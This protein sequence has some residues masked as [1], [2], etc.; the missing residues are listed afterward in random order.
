MPDETEPLKEYQRRLVER[1]RVLAELTWR[2]GAVANARLFVFVV[3]AVVVWFVFGVHRLHPAWIAIPVLAFLSLVVIHDRVLQSM[4]C[5]KSGIEYYERGIAR[6][7]DRWTGTGWDG[8]DLAPKEH[9]YADDLDLFGPGS[10]FQLLCTAQ[11]RAGGKTLADWLCTSATPDEIRAR[12]A[13]VEELRHR[14]DLREELA[15]HGRAIQTHV[16]PEAIAAWASAPPVFRSR[17][18]AVVA[19]VVSLV[20]IVT[21]VSL[22]FGAPVLPF[23]A[24]AATLLALHLATRRRVREVISAADE[25]GRELDLAGRVLARLE[26]EPFESPYLRAAQDGFR[27]GPQ[28]ASAAIAR[29]RRLLTMREASLNMLFAPIAPFL[30]WDFHFARAIDAWRCRCGPAIG[31]WLEGVGRLEALCAL[32]S[33]AYEHPA[34][35]FP[36]VEGNGLVFNGQGLGHPLLPVARCV[37]NNVVLD[38][39]QRLLIVSGS[40]MSGKTVLLRTVGTNLILASAGAPV[41]AHALTFSSLKAGATL[42]I[43][44]TIQTGESRFYA[45]IKRIRALMDIAQGPTPLLFLLDEILHGTN[46][47]DRRIGAR[48]ILRG[49]IDAGAIGIVTTHDLA[50]TELA[51]EFGGR[52][53][54]AHFEDHLEDSRLVFDYLL[55]PGVVKKSN[56]LDLMRAIGL[57]VD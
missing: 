52:A 45:E 27:E 53:I 5:M 49:L 34:D 13:A 26:R 16:F 44:D 17:W 3:G 19:C 2:D 25:P 18:M 24:A 33:Y 10:L 46:S 12:Q 14:I 7:E 1:R 23:S 22:W 50:I 51:D 32:A 8:A 36:S 6:I 30:M 40:N 57:H 56:A 29:L 37:R 20:T 11:T 48:A 43:H 15:Y 39:Q 28:P 42:N 9:P 47:W 55:R 41:R 38:E 4:R 35:P 31:R 21:A 54:N